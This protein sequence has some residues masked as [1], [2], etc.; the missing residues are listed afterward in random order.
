M[1]K[2]IANARVVNP[3]TL[4]TNTLRSSWI[5]GSRWVSNFTLIDGNKIYKRRKGQRIIKKQTMK[6]E[7]S[8]TNSERTGENIPQTIIKYRNGCGYDSSTIW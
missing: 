3:N 2:M 6:Y 5:A 7:Q 4:P 8:K 1:E